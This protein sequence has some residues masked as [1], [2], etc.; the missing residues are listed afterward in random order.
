MNSNRELLYN[1]VYVSK[2]QRPE[3]L[4]HQPVKTAP[5]TVVHS[6]QTY[7]VLIRNLVYYYDVHTRYIL[8]PVKK[9]ASMTLLNNIIHTHWDRRFDALWGITILS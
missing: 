6:L 3:M 7:R 8:Y 1:N 9:F 5:G 4:I 2:Q